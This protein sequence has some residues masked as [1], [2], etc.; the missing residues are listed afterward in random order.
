MRRPNVYQRSAPRI[1]RDTGQKSG[2]DYGPAAR[3]TIAAVPVLLMEAEAAGATALARYL[4]QALT[5]AE[6][7]VRRGG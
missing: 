6:G 3:A 2:A 1:R 5:E 7:I 4:G